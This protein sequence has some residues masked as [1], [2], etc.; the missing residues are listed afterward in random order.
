MLR[1]KLDRI[2]SNFSSIVIT[3]A[4]SFE[5]PVCYSEKYKGFGGNHGVRAG[6]KIQHQLSLTNGKAK[7][8][9]CSATRSDFKSEIIQPQKGELHLFDL[10]YFEFPRFI[11]FDHKQA[12]YLSRLKLN[13]VVWVN[14]ER[15]WEVLDWVKLNSKIHASEVLEL[16]VKLGNNKELST[17]MFVR[18]LS[19]EISARKRKELKR[20]CQRH[21]NTPTKKRLAICDL[22]IHITNAPAALIDKN[23]VL[24]I[25]SLRWQIEL[26]FKG[27][28]SFMNIHKVRPAKIER[29]ECQIYGALIYGLCLFKIAFEAK[30]QIWKMHQIEISEL[31]TIRFLST[32][33]E[34]LDQLVHPNQTLKAQHWMKTLELIRST[35]KKEYKNKL[36]TPMNTIKIALS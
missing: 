4:T 15:G 16:E 3:D 28:K 10:G 25:Y 34:L 13:T 9:V 21:K 7:I 6:M 20:Y 1:I 33:I 17:R 29:L 19:P 14:T 22:S 24:K 32:F 18:K 27:W 36:K 2:T 23:E 11:E 30:V 31:K 12:Y 35:C 26:Q 5:L 8:E